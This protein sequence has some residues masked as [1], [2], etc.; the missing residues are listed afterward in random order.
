M[1]IV[2]GS[3]RPSDGSFDKSERFISESCGYCCADR[4]VKTPCGGIEFAE[5]LAG[6]VLVVGGAKDSALVGEAVLV[7]A[8][9]VE[10]NRVALWDRWISGDDPPSVFSAASS[11]LSML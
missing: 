6:G 4:K 7:A 2:E 11:S 8:L 5:S 3:R 1:V 10:D 9:A